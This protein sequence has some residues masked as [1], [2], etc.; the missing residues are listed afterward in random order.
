MSPSWHEQEARALRGNALR[1]R[2][3]L[4]KAAAAFSQAASY[5]AWPFE[6]AVRAAYCRALSLLRWEQG[7]L[8]EAA[9]L[10]VEAGRAAELPRL[11]RDIEE[12]FAAETAGLDVIRRVYQ[13]FVAGL[14]KGRRIPWQVLAMAE[15]TLRRVFRSRGYRVERLPFA[16]RTCSRI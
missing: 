8:D 15:T 10:L 1:I 13:E 12:V 9:A 14:E 2:G 16:E 4:E 7:R 5:L 3:E 11:L 6:S